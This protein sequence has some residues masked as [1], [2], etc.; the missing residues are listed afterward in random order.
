[1]CNSPITSARV[2]AEGIA[3]SVNEPSEGAASGCT[4]DHTNERASA[5]TARLLV[6]CA[7]LTAPALAA[8]I[9]GFPTRFVRRGYLAK[10]T[11]FTLAGR[12]PFSRLV[13]PVPE[14]GGLGVHLTLDLA[15]PCA[16]R[17]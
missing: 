14:P 2:E 12:S 8:G 7:G 10:G 16:L 1:M 6:N 4:N 9:E 3:L 15:G 13:Y 17:P 11:Y 5:L